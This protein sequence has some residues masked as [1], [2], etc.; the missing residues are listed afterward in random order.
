M[1]LAVVI[2]ADSEI[3]RVSGEADC[4]VDEEIGRRLRGYSG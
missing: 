3:S 2:A 4:G 1:G